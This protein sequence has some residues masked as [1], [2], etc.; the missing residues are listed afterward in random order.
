MLRPGVFFG[1]DRDFGKRGV[2][3]TQCSQQKFLFN[4]YVGDLLEMDWNVEA[5][6]LCGLDSSRPICR[7]ALKLSAALQK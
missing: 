3:F 7:R 4:R 2:R 5:R 6:R 1:S